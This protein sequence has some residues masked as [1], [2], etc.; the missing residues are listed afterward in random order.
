EIFRSIQQPTVL[1]LEDLHW[2]S[3]DVEIVGQLAEAT[4]DKPLLI[5]ATYRDDEMPYLPEDLPNA[6]LLKLMRLNKEAIRQLTS[7]MLGVAG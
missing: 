6:E 1:M 5:I 7:S 4:K 3:A 2:A